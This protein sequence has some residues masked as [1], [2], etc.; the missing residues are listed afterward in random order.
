MALAREDR[1]AAETQGHRQANKERR[2]QSVTV[3][4]RS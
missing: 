4:I 1:E 2:E 3:F